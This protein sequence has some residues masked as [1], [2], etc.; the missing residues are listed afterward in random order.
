[1]PA[2]RNAAVDTDLSLM[3]LVLE[4]TKPV[5]YDA[6]VTKIAVQLLHENADTRLAAL[7]W[8]LMLHKKAPGEIA[9]R[10]IFP[11]LLKTLS[12]PV[13][14]VPR[15][16]MS[17]SVLSAVTQVARV[18]IELLAQFSSG[19]DGAIFHTFIVDLLSLFSTDRVLLETRG[20]LIVRQ[21][22]LFM[23]PELIYRTLAEILTKEDVRSGRRRRIRLA[24]APDNRTLAFAVSW[25][26]T[27]TSSC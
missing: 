24:H 23:N 15:I 7:E 11:A 20:S 21:L 22:C 26:S 27:S 1:M 3:S 4:T 18:D 5:A 10:E 17:I 25:C 19:E 14:E 2:I 6:C 16:G 9:A 12:D 8:L 13:E